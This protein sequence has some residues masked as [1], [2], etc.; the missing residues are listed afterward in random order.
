MTERVD[1]RFACGVASARTNADWWQEN[2]K[3]GREVKAGDKLSVYGYCHM[4]PVQSVH[5]DHD[6]FDGRPIIEVTF[7]N[8]HE[9]DSRMMAFGAEQ[10]V[11]I[12]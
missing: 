11:R 2:T 6:V 8:D 10:M 4:R 5:H 3:P 12:D 7:A 1:Q 9:R